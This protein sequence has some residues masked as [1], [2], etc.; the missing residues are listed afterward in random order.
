[1]DITFPSV[2]P[3]SPFR[4]APCFGAERRGRQSEAPSSPLKKPPGE[5]T[6]PTM[7]A[8]FR[9]NL[10]GRVPSRGERHLVQQTARMHVA[11]SNHIFP[12][13]LTLSLRERSPR[14]LYAP[15]TP[16]PGDVRRFLPLFPTQEGGEGWG[17][18][19]FFFWIT[20]LSGS[21]PA[22]ASRGEREKVAPQTNSHE[23]IPG[24]LC[25]R[26]VRPPAASGP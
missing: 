20:P 14:T 26:A 6:G 4:D 7:H 25:P 13:T 17:E 12:L 9:G 22:R 1:M 24:K 8:D 23:R 15:S 18:E 16:E 2:G 11:Y 3:G 5:G 10:V 19:E 21:L